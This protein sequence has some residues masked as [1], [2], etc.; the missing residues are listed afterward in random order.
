M[1]PPLF[2]GVADVYRT[3]AGN[4]KFGDRWLSCSL[5]LGAST[6][7]RQLHDGLRRSCMHDLRHRVGGVHTFNRRRR[8]QSYSRTLAAHPRTGERSGRS[9]IGSLTLLRFQMLHASSFQKRRL[10]G[11]DRFR[12]NAS[13]GLIP[14]PQE[15][16]VLKRQTVTVLIQT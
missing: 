11:R 6:Y 3:L 1:Q 7:I 8:R 2:A 9:S 14:S 12:H 13:F 16:P 4:R 5:A 15:V 10:Q